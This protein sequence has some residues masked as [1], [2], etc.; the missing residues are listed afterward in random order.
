[1]EEKDSKRKLDSFNKI[2]LATSSINYMANCLY[3]TNEQ[4]KIA[5]HHLPDHKEVLG[6]GIK[7]KDELLEATVNKLHE[8]ME[9]LGDCMN[10]SDCISPIDVRVTKEAFAIVS[11]KYDDVD[12]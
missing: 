3:T 12:K 1:M 2:L 8:I 9:D 11:G 7:H 5:T 10:H 6:D 4:V